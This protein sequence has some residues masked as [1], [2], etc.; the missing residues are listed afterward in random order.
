[1]EI[2]SNLGDRWEDLPLKFEWFCL[3]GI[4]KPREDYH[5][6]GIGGLTKRSYIA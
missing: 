5:K 3:F 2:L 4:D 6:S 1:M